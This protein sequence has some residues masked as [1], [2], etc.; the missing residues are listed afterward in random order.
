M[1]PPLPEKLA[2]GFVTAYIDAPNAPDRAGAVAA[3][4]D[5]L[6]AAYGSG[7]VAGADSLRDKLL[8][9]IESNGPLDSQKLLALTSK[10]F[11]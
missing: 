1:T 3:L 11:G 2:S 10:L 6:S 4:T 9:E 5:V 8:R 7:L